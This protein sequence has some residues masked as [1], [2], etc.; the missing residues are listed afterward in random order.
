[1][2]PI[3]FRIS[4]IIAAQLLESS[5]SV[6]CAMALSPHFLVRVASAFA[7][8]STITT[9]APAC[10]IISEDARPIPDAAP[11]TTAIFPASTFVI[12]FLPEFSF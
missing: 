7:L 4:G 1:M 3:F 11:V 10:I 9:V 8:R 12:F 5:K 6:T 2:R